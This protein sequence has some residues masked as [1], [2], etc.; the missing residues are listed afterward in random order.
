M[1]RIISFLE[2]N[3]NGRNAIIKHLK[4]QGFVNTVEIFNLT[5]ENVK[6]LEDISNRDDVQLPVATRARLRLAQLIRAEFLR[7]N[8]I[9]LKIFKDVDFKLK[10][11]LYFGSLIKNLTVNLTD[12]KQSLVRRRIDLAIQRYCRETLVSIKIDGMKDHIFSTLSRPF[13]N[14]EDVVF[15]GNL[16]ENASKFNKWFPKMRV[17]VLKDVKFA[18]PTCINNHFQNLSTFK[19]FH[20]DDVTSSPQIINMGNLFVFLSKNS[21]LTALSL[22]NGIYGD[23][24]VILNL[25]LLQFIRQTLPFLQTLYIHVNKPVEYMHQPEFVR[26][27]SLQSLTL[28]LSRPEYLQYLPIS[29][30]QLKK[31]YIHNYGEFP[32][33]PM[34]KTVKE[35]IRMYLLEN[36]SI[37]DF[38]FFGHYMCGGMLPSIIFEYLSNLRNVLVFA[39]F[40]YYLKVPTIYNVEITPNRLV[41]YWESGDISRECFMKLWRRYANAKNI[42][43]AAWRV[44]ARTDKNVGLSVMSFKRVY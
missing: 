9:A 33:K 31:L 6:Q 14:V 39:E 5:D 38:Y 3:A 24:G 37:R 13:P 29:S 2:V 11:L 10:L 30:R 12:C 23:K 34:S 32:Q 18:V 40:F 28:Y 36:N 7:E 8:G 15:N 42:D 20:Y 19:I 27:D 22:K 25:P 17:L 43:V 35:F 44:A 1:N 41:V 4:L 16:G 21:Q 26:I